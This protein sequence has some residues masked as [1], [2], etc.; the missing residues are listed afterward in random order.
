MFSQLIPSL[1]SPS[2]VLQLTKD[3]SML[4]API[5]ELPVE[6]NGSKPS[7]AQISCSCCNKQRIKQIFVPPPEYYSVA[8]CILL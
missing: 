8:C 2:S 4:S 3:C 1:S 5:T 6:E 7:A